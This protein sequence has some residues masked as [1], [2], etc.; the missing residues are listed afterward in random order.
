M[1]LVTYLDTVCPDQYIFFPNLSE[2]LLHYQLYIVTLASQYSFSAWYAYDRAF[3]QHIANNPHCSWE[4]PNSLLYNLHVRGQ[5]GRHKCYHCSS[6]DHFALKCSTKLSRSHSQ[7]SSP[8]GPLPAPPLLLHVLA[9][10]KDRSDP[11]GTTGSPFS[12]PP[13]S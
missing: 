1:L 3:R 7:Q 4:V 6:A 11:K 8:P 12:P 9:S 13:S 5:A 2:Q 10:P